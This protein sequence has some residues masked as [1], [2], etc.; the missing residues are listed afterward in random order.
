MSATWEQYLVRVREEIGTLY[1]DIHDCNDLDFYL[2][3]SIAIDPEWSYEP[4]YTV[5]D[6]R[7]YY[8]G[9]SRLC[10][11]WDNNKLERA[12]WSSSRLYDAI[13]KMHEGRWSKA[14]FRH[15]VSAVYS[16]LNEFVTTESLPAYNE[17]ILRTRQDLIARWC[18]YNYCH[19]QDCWIN[20][21]MHSKNA[22]TV[23]I[24]K[25]DMKEITPEIKIDSS[26]LLRQ[27]QESLAK[28]E[29]SKA[30]S[31]ESAKS[32]QL[33]REINAMIKK[34]LIRPDL[35]QVIND[36]LDRPRGSY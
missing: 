13:R 11:L 24:T 34:G 14:Y 29:A 33:T 10:L 5:P 7:R 26:E 6:G 1:E 28:K 9:L 27:H 35:D 4:G 15:V 23:D 31:K 17:N 36:K 21:A 22:I 12:L 16:V 25:I 2:K 19:G 32:R 3:D 30:A 20:A 18:C 8:K